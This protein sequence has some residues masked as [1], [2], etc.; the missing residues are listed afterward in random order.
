LQED[1]R[2]VKTHNNMA[3]CGIAYATDIPDDLNLI[4]LE[5]PR[6]HGPWGSTGAS[7]VFQ[8]S[9]HVAGLNA[10]EDATGV[11]IYELPATP[12]KVKAGL[13]IVAKG[14]KTEPKRYFLGS[15]LVEELEKIK[16][17]PVSY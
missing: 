11:R 14:G 9:A 6:P 2:D 13:D 17:N 5:N 12:A 8:T 3:K 7:E 4:A 1:Y 10:I 15:D 16:A